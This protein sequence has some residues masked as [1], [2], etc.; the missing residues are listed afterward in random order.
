[1][2]FSVTVPLIFETVFHWIS[3]TGQLDSLASDSR[4]CLSPY[5][6]PVASARATDTCHHAQVC[7]WVLDLRQ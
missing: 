3:V 7:L 4:A 5:P 1:M 6:Y 2:A